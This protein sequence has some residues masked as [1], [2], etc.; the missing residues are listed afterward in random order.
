MIYT[1]QIDYRRDE[2]NSLTADEPPSHLAVLRGL[3]WLVFPQESRRFPLF[4]KF[5]FMFIN[6]KLGKTFSSGTWKAKCIQAAILIIS[7]LQFLDERISTKVSVQFAFF[8]LN[9]LNM[10]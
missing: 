9:P 4:I 10:L 3:G 8:L 1:P 5:S 2:I 7:P 6:K